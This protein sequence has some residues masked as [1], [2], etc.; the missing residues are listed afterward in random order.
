MTVGHDN[1]SVFREA[2]AD[3]KESGRFIKSDFN[4]DGI[5][6]EK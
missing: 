6:C 5:K 2:T 1:D 4:D 3:S